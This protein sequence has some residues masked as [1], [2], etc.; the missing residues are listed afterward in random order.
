MRKKPTNAGLRAGTGIALSPRA[1]P[2]RVSL[3]LILFLAISTTQPGARLEAVSRRELTQQRAVPTTTISC[4]RCSLP[5]LRNRI[6]P[7]TFSTSWDLLKQ[8][9]IPRMD[10]TAFRSH[11]G[12][13]AR[14][15]FCSL[16][17][18]LRSSLLAFVNPFLHHCE[19][20]APS[21]PFCRVRH[22]IRRVYVLITRCWRF[23]PVAMYIE[24]YL[25]RL[26]T[27]P[28][29]TSGPIL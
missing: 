15:F 1:Y 10:W 18:H 25:G 28:G 26:S 4:S 14:R 29:I 24:I 2:L 8:D 6:I 12:F 16:D 23:D 5:T 3:R 21:A 19:T 20:A 22:A 7:R 13:W 27:S 11:L 17:R 9:R